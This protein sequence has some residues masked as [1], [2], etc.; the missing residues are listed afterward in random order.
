MYI[1]CVY[2]YNDDD[3]VVEVVVVIV[4]INV[5]TTNTTISKRHLP[6]SNGSIYQHVVGVLGVTPPSGVRGE[7]SE[8][9]DGNWDNGEGRDS[10]DEDGST[11]DN[12]GSS[13][14]CVE[15]F[16]CVCVSGM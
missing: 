3:D 15:V 2:F 13:D 8:E 9:D 12:R 1:F 5:H 14:I 4:I 7:A 6:T 16:M 11:I 10:Q